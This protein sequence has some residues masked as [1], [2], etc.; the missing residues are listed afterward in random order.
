M[1]LSEL[2][3]GDTAE[4]VSVQ[5]GEALAERLKTLNVSTG[6]IVKVLRLAPFRGGEMLEAEGVRLS[7]RRSL[8]EKVIV[9]R[10][11]G[12]RR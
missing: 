1:K 7:I 3:A 12:E 2:A 10:T 4:I 6:K 9:R 8:A 5:C 11:E